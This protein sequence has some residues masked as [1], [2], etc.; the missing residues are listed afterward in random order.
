VFDE[1]LV[2]TRAAVP[3]GLVEWEDLII[4]R[5]CSDAIGRATGGHGRPSAAASPTDVSGYPADARWTELHAEPG[6]AHVRRHGAFPAPAAIAWR[7][8]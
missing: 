3:R 6:P 8:A 1:Q 4:T 7:R 5:V 2:T